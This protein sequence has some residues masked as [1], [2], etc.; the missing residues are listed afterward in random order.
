MRV[1]IIGRGLVRARFNDILSLTIVEIIIYVLAD[2]HTAK[3]KNPSSANSNIPVIDGNAME[4]E[5]FNHTESIWRVLLDVVGLLI[6][7]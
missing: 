1:I 4:T 6:R 7:E 5:K 3:N 2:I